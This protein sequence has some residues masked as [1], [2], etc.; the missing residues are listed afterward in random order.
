M[1]DSHPLSLVNEIHSQNCALRRRNHANP[2]KKSQTVDT[3]RTIL[4]AAFFRV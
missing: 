3:L 4:A 2:P 1:V